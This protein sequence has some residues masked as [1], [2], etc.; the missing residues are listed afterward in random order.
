MP[1]QATLCITGKLDYLSTLPTGNF[2]PHSFLINRP[3]GTHV[4]D[5]MSYNL[6]TKPL[7]AKPASLALHKGSDFV[8]SNEN[9]TAYIVNCSAGCDQPTVQC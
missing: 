7:S 1:R 4:L 3:I 2:T 5:F 9:R 6:Q 8:N